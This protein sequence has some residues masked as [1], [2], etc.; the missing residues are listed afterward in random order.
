MIRELLAVGSGGALGCM[1]RYALSGLLLA[2]YAPAGLPVGTFAVNAAG[3][4]LIGILLATVRDGGLSLLLVT[5][6]CGGFTTFSTFSADA[7]RLLRDGAW[8]TAGLYVALSVAIC[9]AGAAL[10][11]WIGTTVTKLNA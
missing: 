7:V 10:G 2:G 3:S 8:G 4:L 5:G 11:L 1:A 6:F 9:I